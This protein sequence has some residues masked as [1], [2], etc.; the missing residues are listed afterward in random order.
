MRNFIAVCIACLS[1]IVAL[2]CGSSDAPSGQATMCKKLQECNLLASGTSEADCE[3]NVQKNYTSSQINDCAN[4][5]NGKS[6]TTIV[7]GACDAACPM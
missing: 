1:G 2:S 7:N 6:C 3:Q 4:C 5:A